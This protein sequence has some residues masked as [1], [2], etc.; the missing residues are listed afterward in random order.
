MTTGFDDF[1]SGMAAVRMGESPEGGGAHLD[2][3]KRGEELWETREKQRY[4]SSFQHALSE[5]AENI[6]TI[7]KSGAVRTSYRALGGA[8][9]WLGLGRESGAF[10]RKSGIGGRTE[11]CTKLRE[12]ILKKEGWDNLGTLS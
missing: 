9:R 7:W 6:R 8:G 10:D 12:W 3:G 1:A 4:K 5:L 11:E 2:E